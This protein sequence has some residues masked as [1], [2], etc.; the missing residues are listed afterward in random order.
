M[1]ISHSLRFVY[2]GPPKTASTSMHIWLR[3]PLLFDTRQDIDTSKTGGQHDWIIPRDAAGYYVLAT[4]REH[5]SWLDSL[6]RQNCNDSIDYPGEPLMDY[7]GF[8]S[9]RKTSGNPFYARELSDYYPAVV[10]CLLRC[11]R[12]AE[13][14]MRLPFVSMFHGKLNR[15]PHENFNKRTPNKKA[16][17]HEVVPRGTEDPIIWPGR[18]PV[19]IWR[20]RGYASR[21]G[22][23]PAR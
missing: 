7:G 6:W 15:I 19:S 11:E 1:I 9:W 4:T 22:R 2:I 13:D 8:L 10:D 5:D 20:R 3:Q 18:E 12:L 17:K 21:Q 23:H 14:A 16:T